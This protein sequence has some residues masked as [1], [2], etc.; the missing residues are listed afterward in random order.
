MLTDYWVIALLLAQLSSF[1]LVAGAVMLSRQIIRRWSANEFNEEQLMLE[2]RSYLVGSIV[3]FV[4]IFQVAA[5]FMFLNTA[6]HHLTGVIKGAMCADGVL[7]VNS[8]GKSLLY[9]KMGAMIFYV[10]YLFLNYL[11]NSEPE[12]PLTPLKYWLI[13]PVFLLIGIDLVY[14]V[15]FFYNIEPDVIA[16]CC[17]VSFVAEGA[18]GYFKLFTSNFTTGWLWTFGISG[19]LLAVTLLV[20]NRLA[21]LKLILGAVFITSAIYSLKYFFVKYI[22]GLPSHNCLY[23]I[24]WAKH[25]LIGYVFFGGYY[26]LATTLTGALLL[27]VCKPKLHIQHTR[28]IYKMRWLSLATVLILMIIPLIYWWQW[29]GTL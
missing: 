5:L 18:P 29:N 17:S 2:R 6:N 27:R 7:G 28:L 14:M 26:T 8:Y 19:V 13:F 21:L 24:F 12:Y 23:D 3:Q 11:D 16:T 1:V 15:L 4:L 10:V 22:Y 25:Y 20:S 9:V